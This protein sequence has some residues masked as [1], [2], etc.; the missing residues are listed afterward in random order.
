MEINVIYVWIQER[1]ES[2]FHPHSLE[3]DNYDEHVA[4]RLYSTSY[5]GLARSLSLKDRQNLEA[6][7]DCFRLGH[8][9]P[10]LMVD[11][12]ASSRVQRTSRFSGDFS[13]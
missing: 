4:E 9:S 5:P 2:S 7:K 8:R 6:E 10:T 13:A 1:R 11:G 12:Q 3:V